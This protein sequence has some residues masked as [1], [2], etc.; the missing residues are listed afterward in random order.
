MTMTGMAAKIRCRHVAAC[1]AAFLTVAAEH[2]VRA[3]ART[4]AD[5]FSE[6]TAEWVRGNPNLSTSAR[7]FAGQDQERLER[8]LT[9]ETDAYRRARI[10]LA[11]R[12]LADLRKFD[13][14]A[15]TDADRLSADLME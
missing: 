8:T 3:Q 1:V 5:F 9:P 10:S 2:D 6:F 15:M 14:A 12:G 13:R 4:I 7:Y 11:R